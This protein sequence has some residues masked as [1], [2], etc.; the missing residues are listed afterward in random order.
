M[1]RIEDYGLIGDLQTAALVSR[2]G[3]IDWLCLPR[4]D[5][6]AI[7]AALL[8]DSENGHWTIQPEGEFHSPG[9]SYRGD[10]LVLETELETSTGAVRLIDFMPPRGKAPD[11]VRI[12][13]GIHG[14]VDMLME[15]VL[16]FD[17][18]SI[19]P[20]VRTIDDTLVAIAGPDAVSVRTPVE[21]EGRNLRTYAEFT[22]EEGDRV[23][24]VLTWTPSHEPLPEPVDAE[25]ALDGDRRLL[26][27]VD[28]PLHRDRALGAAHAP[29]SPH[30]EG[31]HVRT[32]GRHRRRP[33]DLAAGGARRRPQLGLPVLLAARR[34]ADAARVPESGLRRRSARLARL[35]A[36]CDRRRSRGHPGHVRRRR[37]AAPD[38]ARAAVARRLRG[39]ASRCGS[40]TAPPDQLQ[41]DVYGEIVDALHLARKRGL[42]ASD[43]AWALTRKV[44]DW[45]ETGWREPDQG[46]WEVRGPRRH[47]THSK[48][49]AWVAFDRAVKAIESL[50]RDGPL[51]RWRATRDAIRDDVLEHGYNAER[52]S[53][54]QYYGSDRL[55]AS[56]LL[57]PLVGFLPATDERVL[58]TVEAI[59][60]ELMRDGFVERYRAD[61]ENVDVDGLPPG[62]GVFLPCSFWLVA[63]L[64]QQGRMDEAVAL[65]ERLL[66]L[67]NDLGLLAE[68]YDPEQ[69]SARRQLPAGVHASRARRD[70]VHARATLDR[71]ETST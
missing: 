61:D 35:A 30:A 44:F 65:Y 26:G 23:P 15:L 45:L 32:D 33:D 48:V 47:F 64:A 13:E 40:E 18:G 56:L 52:G 55:D 8:G 58:G 57:I 24:F 66:S 71:D 17:Y 16:R 19:V 4:F 25:H 63:V 37:R 27:G 54:V 11:V 68:E 9:R 28:R 6:G 34:D 1:A 62:E 36:A 21:L 31:A 67:G 5:S 7:F 38:R 29:V 53:F 70:R 39:L 20:W 50:G 60:R 12:V 43:P 14:R 10:T 59:Q 49:M 3:C 46:I 2:H 51:E 41:L 69:R 42:E 22:V